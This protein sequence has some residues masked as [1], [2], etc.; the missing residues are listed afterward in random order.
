MMHK[1]LIFN[2]IH[3]EH[4]ELYEQE[5]DH[6]YIQGVPEQN[7]TIG[8]GIMLFLKTK[9]QVWHRNLAPLKV[10]REVCRIASS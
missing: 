3:V 1:F 5:L 8:Q 10:Q 7:N 2:N 4:S 9:L 6:N